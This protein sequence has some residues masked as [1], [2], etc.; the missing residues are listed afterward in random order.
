[1]ERN[2]SKII[3]KLFNS[4]KKMPIPVKASFWFTVCS[5]MQKGIAFVTVPI[6]TR[7]LTTDEFGIYQVYQSWI[8]VLSIFATLKLAAGVYNNAM[9]KFKDTR[10]EM[11]ASFQGLSTTVSFILFM[12][13]LCFRS[14]WEKLFTLP[15]I[16]VCIMFLEIF[17][18]VSLQLWAAKQRFEYQYKT[19]VIVNVAMAFLAPILSI[20]G[21][22]V[23]PYNRGIVRALV[24]SGINI[25]VCLF[26]YLRIFYKG[27]CFFHKIYWEFAL[28][29]NVPLIP[30]YLSMSILNQVDRIMISYICG[31]GEAGVYGLAYSVGMLVSIMINAVNSSLIP[32]IYKAINENQY[33]KLKK[34]TTIVV[35]I[36]AILVVGIIGMAP[37]II[38]IIGGKEYYGAIW[39]VPP[40]AIS[41]FFIFLY[42]LYAD[43]E[44]YYEK[45][46][47]V[48]VASFSGAVINVVLN[49]IFIPCFG[50]LTAGFTTLIS[51]II[52]AII[53]YFFM[54]KILRQKKLEAVYN[55]KAGWGISILLLIISSIF[56][57]LYL[58]NWIRY[59]FFIILACIFV[60]FIRKRGIK[61][62]NNSR[63]SN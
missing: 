29:F 18:S 41:A 59:L 28:K 3:E 43:I 34:V 23:F 6:F 37:E 16:L 30:H 50:Y 56:M 20:I 26:F 27:K 13:F 11:T 17:L 60:F 9:L 14:Q 33:K 19:L 48:M 35:G 7:L 5:I 4:Y 53:H 1:M 46:G 32:Y 38:L 47:Y 25:V 44:F 57:G 21:I 49:L 12:F 2:I 22:I 40:V 55:E 10:E 52:V 63:S 51:Y 36:I 58:Y 31:V 15:D 24:F 45:T 61:Y 54:K 62:E 39:I 8:D 42:S